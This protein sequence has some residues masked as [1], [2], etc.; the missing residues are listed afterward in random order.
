MSYS[1]FA[2]LSRMK[3]INRWA[4]MRNA[5]EENLSEH[6]LEVA[7][8][9]HALCV[10]GNK[11]WNKNLSV[12]KAVLRAL[13]HDAAEI[14]TGDMPTPVKY[15]KEELKTAY[16]KVEKEAE[17]RLLSTL[18]QYLTEEFGKVFFPED[19][20][21]LTYEN[22]LIKAADKLSALIKCEEELRAGNQE[23]STAAMSTRK[24][25]EEMAEELPELKCFMEDFLP[26][27]G[28]TLDELTEE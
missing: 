20:A 15:R 7:I 17:E 12:E 10:I 25:V 13:Y 26:E 18:P 24:K 4:L 14:L 6:C 1:Y 11:K 28:K 3:Y 2:L 16:K 19:Y 21:T 9:T 22:K 27:Y 5:R 8:L 23:F